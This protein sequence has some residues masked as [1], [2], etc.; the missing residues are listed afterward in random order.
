M[1]LPVVAP[2]HLGPFGTD[3]TEFLWPVEP[4]GMNGRRDVRFGDLAPVRYA[5]ALGSMPIPP[6]ALLA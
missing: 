2:R 4:G 3:L 5:V 1:K 6:A